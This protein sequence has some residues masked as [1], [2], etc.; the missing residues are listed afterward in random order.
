[1]LSPYSRLD[2]VN[3]VLREVLADEL[4]RLDDESL[5]LVTVTGVRADPDLRHAVVW[6]SDLSAAAGSE[7][8]AAA[9]VRHRVRLQAA[10][11]RQLRL[12]RTPGLA[13]QPDPAIAVGTRVEQILRGLHAG[14][15]SEADL[16]AG[17][18]N[19]G[20][21][22]QGFSGRAEGTDAAESRESTESTGSTD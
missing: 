12:K 14:D 18:V 6:Y 9:L 8:V 17:D 19:E 3:E 1:A 4:E 20:G 2:R 15:L 13:F 10:V 22:P 11:G 16:D 21:A 7:A 5:D